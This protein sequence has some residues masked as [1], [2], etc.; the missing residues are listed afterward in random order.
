MT[1]LQAIN[2]MLSAIGEAPITN[3]ETATQADVAM[4]LNILDEAQREMCSMG[5]KFNMEFG[6]ELPPDDTF[7]WED[8]SGETTTLNIFF[9]PT[10]LLDF[11][12]TQSVGQECL[13]LAVRK[14]R[15]Y[16][17]VSDEL[18]TVFYDR[19]LNRDGLDEDKYPYL[20]IDPVWLF[21]FEDVPEVAQRFVTIRAARQFIER[22]VGS[23]T[24]AGFQQKD[25]DFAYRNLKREYGKKDKANMARTLRDTFGRR[26]VSHTRKV[27]W[28]DSPGPTSSSSSGSGSNYLGP[29]VAGL[30]FWYDAMQETL[31]ASTSARNRADAAPP[32]SDLS[33]I[34]TSGAGAVVA[35]TI[36]G[37]QA[38]KDTNADQFE[39]NH[40][41][42]SFLPAASYT[43]FVVINITAIDNNLALGVIMGM[44][45]FNYSTDDIGQAPPYSLG[46]NLS[47]NTFVPGA[48]LTTGLHVLSISVA[49][50]GNW[51]MYDNGTVVATGADLFSNGG[52]WDVRVFDK[53][54]VGTTYSLGE[55]R[56]YLATLS[57]EDRVAI[58]D[59]LTTKWS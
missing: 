12:V 49:A 55:A 10:N 37:H 9:P 57:A 16:A 31:G 30:T 21:D 8:T 26:R 43:A 48:A 28:R 58:Q 4:A 20:Y 52:Q 19:A 2:T 47:D 44:W 11:K 54:D 46:A 45:P 5:W 15:L 41:T 25:E 53:A 6:F 14:S 50:N 7:D 40:V 35:S 36:N 3:V 51:T 33:E 22:V 29:D 56:M 24:L 39:L 1:K 27:D 23:N 18:V 32:N 42:G 59:F 34:Y 17:D 38:L 13:D